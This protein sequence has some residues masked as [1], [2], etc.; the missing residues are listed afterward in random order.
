MPDNKM[1]Q[2]DA[3]RI[4][5]SQAR[6]PAYRASRPLLTSHKATSGKD[7]GGYGFASGAQSAGDRNANAATT[8]GNAG[9]GG[10]QGG[11]A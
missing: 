8:T 6:P 10:G 9:T 1:S 3:G 7:I 5:S 4:Q 2:S 11:G